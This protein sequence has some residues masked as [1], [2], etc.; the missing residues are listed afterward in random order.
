VA[1]S[2]EIIDETKK[3]TS[4]KQR[5][6]DKLIRLKLTAHALNSSQSIVDH[7]SSDLVRQSKL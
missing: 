7:S 5:R 4:K 1:N 2:L 6:K 3:K